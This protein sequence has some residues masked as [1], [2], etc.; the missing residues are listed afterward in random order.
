MATKFVLILLSLLIAKSYQKDIEVVAASEQ[1]TESLDE[2]LKWSQSL[3]EIVSLYSS[4]STMSI[5][6]CQL[7]RQKIRQ[8]ISVSNQNKDL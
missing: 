6:V 4:L 8:K 5:M 1:G 2:K 3:C 7:L